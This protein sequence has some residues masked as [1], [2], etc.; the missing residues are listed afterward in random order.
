MLRKS[1]I[2]IYLIIIICLALA[3]FLEKYYGTEFVLSNIYTSWWMCLF[4]A[5]LFSVGVFYIIKIR[6]KRI[7]L[8]TLHFALSLILIGAFITHL[9]SKNGVI[10]LRQGET[11]SSYITTTNNNIDS[12][13][14]LPF[15]IRLNGFKVINH[16]GTNTALDYISEI[17]IIKKNRHEDVIVSM[18]NIYTCD[19]YR[20]YQSSFDEDGKGTYLSLNSDPVG[21]PITY[22]GYALF[23]IGLIWILI[24]KHGAFRQLLRHPLLKQKIL[25]ISLLI[26]LNSLPLQ[27]V[28]ALQNEIA[29][30]FCKINVLYNGRICPLQTYALDFTKKI[31]GKRSYKDYSAEQVFTGFLFWRDQWMKESI[32]RIKDKIVRDRLHLPEY[33]SGEMLF[34]KNH[35]Y[36]IGPYI[37]EYFRGNHDKFHEGINKLDEKVGLIMELNNKTPLK[38]FPYTKGGETIWYGPNDTYP[39]YIEPERKEYM[40]KILLYLDDEA[41]NDKMDEMNESID[42]LIKYQYTYSGNSIPSKVQLN[43][44]YIYNKYPFATILFM[45]CL[46][47]GFIC[48]FYTIYTLTRK[49]PEKPTKKTYFVYSEIIVMAISF[50]IL[51]FCL[52]L[53]WII[54]GTIP[55][56]NGYETMLVMA[57]I[58]MLTSIIIYHKFHIILTFGFLLSGFFL[59]VSHISQMD[60]QITH[61]MPVLKSPL[62]TIHVSVIMMAYALLAL[63]FI[64]GL[65]AVL[66]RII[67]GKGAEGLKDQLEALQI[68]SKLFLYPSITAL[69]LG[70]FIGAIWAN[71][72]WGTYWSWDP[73]ETW[74]LITLMIYVIPVHRS[75]IRRLSKPINY[76]LFMTVAFLTIL[77][78]YFGVN[79]FLGGMH[80]YA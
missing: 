75:I 76:H 43:A 66:L 62:L 29:N 12:S 46:T 73:K 18:N 39:D 57:W 42:K 16:S 48:L 10:H 63:T 24:D 59:L 34:Q 77:M 61:I 50:I 53:R 23:F 3:T 45:V 56:S 1:L 11:V 31:Y 78:T 28:P 70:I 6:F 2:A 51:T 68:L 55:M 33:I 26:S 21:I 15:S 40:Q 17:T 74:A 79:Y 52:I 20:L 72:S 44:E 5:I 67:R 80:S 60:P 4:W 14:Q 49:I 25:S 9:T 41:R 58:I 32:I 30:K 69:G 7:S 35:G 36:I 47:M 38:V 19:N 64:C 71:I 65:T 22:T 13:E 27:A 8:I 37:N 54:R